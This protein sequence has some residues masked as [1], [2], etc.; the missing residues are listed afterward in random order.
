MACGNVCAREPEHVSC[1]SFRRGTKH[2]TPFSMTQIFERLREEGGA[3]FGDRAAA[4][5]RHEVAE[6]K[7]PGVGLA[8]GCHGDRARGPVPG[9]GPSG[10]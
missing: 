2:F 8:F 4:L 9:S 1:P 3:R 10:G 5:K 7:G 6:E